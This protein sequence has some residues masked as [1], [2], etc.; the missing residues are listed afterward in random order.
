MKSTI[1]ITLLA[2]PGLLAASPQSAVVIV[3]VADVWSRPLAVGEK[4][5]DELRETQVL[6]SEQVLI[7]ESS[8]SWVRIEAIEQPTFRQHNKWEGYPGWMEKKS[9]G[10]VKSAPLGNSG[11]NTLP[12]D[13]LQFAQQMIGTPYLWGG[14]SKEDGFDCS[15]L[16]HLAFRKHG[17]KI[18]R[19]AHEQWMKA[20][21][22]KRVDLKPKD[23]IFSA[24]AE[25]PKKITHVALYVGNGQII[26]APQTGGVVRTLSF[27][28]KY[29]QDLEKVE[30][31]D[32]VG[33]R[34]VYF[35]SYLH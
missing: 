15:G 5:A 8:G 22:I 13:P 11:I 26:E 6:F 31:G 27:K 2:I 35:G 16:V 23:L 20:K 4:P 1:A 28:E 33:E 17:Q 9:L 30:S 34:F 19:D 29:G 18:P 14:M 21:P 25:N 24:K 12:M 3:P 7:H 10:D 32:R